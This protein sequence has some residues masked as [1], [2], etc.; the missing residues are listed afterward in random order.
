M[1]V[2]A[3]PLRRLLCAASGALL[4]LSSLSA[5]ADLQST[6][7]VSL[8]APGGI[9]SD[10]TPISLQQT[11]APADFATGISTG[12][13]SPIGGMMLAGEE[14]YFVGNTIRVSAYGGGSNQQG[15]SI[16]GYL[17]AAGQHARYV[18]DGLSIAGFT[19]VGASISA[20]DG[21]AAS[22]TSGLDSPAATSLLH[23]VDADTVELYLDDIIF[24]DRGLNTGS[25]ED[26]ADFL[27]TLLTRP[28]EPDPGNQVPEPASLALVLTAALG[29][30]VAK[31]RERRGRHG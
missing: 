12:D 20:F 7:T 29:A 28:G 2:L 1:S 26:H 19:I 17:G 21:Y 18:F 8:I 3:T 11:V 24:T 23:W 9:T 6:V 10:P 16:T 15:Q 25:S 13:G 4:A 27:I 31:R 5:H 30:G 22:G 14:I